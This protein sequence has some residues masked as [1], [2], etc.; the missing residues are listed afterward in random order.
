MNLSGNLPEEDTRPPAG[1][2]ALPPEP[3]RA[4]PARESSGCGKARPQKTAAG[5]LVFGRFGNVRLTQ[6]EHDKLLVEFGDK[7]QRAVEKLDAFIGARG[8]RYKSH[9]MAMHSWVLRAVDEEETGRRPAPSAG[10]VGVSPQGNSL[11]GKPRE[12]TRQAPPA[13]ATEARHGV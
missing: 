4:R 8:D 13:W 9:Y 12:Y 1:E 7:G 2:S 6:E 3:A 11:D 10:R 5:K